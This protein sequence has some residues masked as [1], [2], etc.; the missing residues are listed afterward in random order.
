MK[1]RKLEPR[2]FEVNIKPYE[3][4]RDV[5]NTSMKTKHEQREKAKQT[6]TERLNR[7][8]NGDKV[9]TKNDKFSKERD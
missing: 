2:E 1:Q 3:R 5:I 8:R 6:Q 7:D 9:G 4:I